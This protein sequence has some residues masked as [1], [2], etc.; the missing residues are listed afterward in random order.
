VCSDKA[1]REQ[2]QLIA[3]MGEE[4]ETLAP[5]FISKLEYLDSCMKETVRRYGMLMLVRKAMKDVAF[6]SADGR[7]FVIPKGTPFIFYSYHC[8]IYI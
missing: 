8:F 3:E 5:N 7:E 4:A 1:L 2:T 6:T